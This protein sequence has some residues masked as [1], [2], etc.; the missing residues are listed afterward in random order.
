MVLRWWQAAKEKR[1]AR[2]RLDR[3]NAALDLSPEQRDVAR[4][5]PIIVP[6]E[7]VQTDWPG[8]IALLDETNCAVAWA[9]VRE[10]NVWTYVSNE[11]ADYWQKSGLDWRLIAF[12][13]LLA[14]SA[15]GANG[16]KFDETGMP[17]IKVMI[18]NDAFGPSRLLIP[19]LFDREL[20][21][22]YRVAIPERTCALAF[23]SVLKGQE[24]DDVAGIINGCFQNGTEPMSPDRYPAA[25]FWKLAEASNW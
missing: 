21:P 22:D 1:A 19:H 16:E 23:R 5:F 12:R 18:Q 4:V 14:V 24:E 9:E 2:E 25:A 6:A 15:P 11:L 3:L 7:L 13:N 17:V 20:G 10:D 8:P